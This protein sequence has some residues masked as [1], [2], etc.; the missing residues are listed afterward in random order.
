MLPDGIAR[1]RKD[2]GLTFAR[3]DGCRNNG[4]HEEQI[5]VNMRHNRDRAILVRDKHNTAAL[6]G[7]AARK[8]RPKNKFEPTTK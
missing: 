6:T 1:C 3:C 4:G 7:C 2:T 8:M 5:L